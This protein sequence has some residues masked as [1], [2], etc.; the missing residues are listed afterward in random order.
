MNL[1]VV[2]TDKKSKIATDSTNHDK[3]AATNPTNYHVK[4]DINPNK[5]VILA[6]LRGKLIDKRESGTLWVRYIVVLYLCTYWVTRKLLQI[7]TANHATF[8]IRIRKITVQI[9]GNFWVT[10]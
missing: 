10:Q 8:P 5:C 2:Y 3:I 7:Y 9:C 1:I 4:I 6:Q